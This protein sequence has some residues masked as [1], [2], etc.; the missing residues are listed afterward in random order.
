MIGSRQQ[1]IIDALQ[2]GAFSYEALVGRRSAPT[3][4]PLCDGC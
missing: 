2:A 4:P 1:Q 3:G